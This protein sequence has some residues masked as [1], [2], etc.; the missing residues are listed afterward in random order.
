MSNSIQTI[1]GFE[2]LPNIA[3]IE[4]KI[5]SASSDIKDTPD[6]KKG[7]S[8]I[9]KLKELDQNLSMLKNDYI[10]KYKELVSLLEN[11]VTKNNTQWGSE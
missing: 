2:N 4:N 11:N 5:K 8:D 9:I 6:T 7:K 1:P 3:E 10:I